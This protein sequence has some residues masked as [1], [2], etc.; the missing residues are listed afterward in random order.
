VSSAFVAHVTTV[1]VDS[2]MG[3]SLPLLEHDF[4]LSMEFIGITEKNEYLPHSNSF[5][6]FPGDFTQTYDPEVAL[7][8]LVNTF[9]SDIKP[10]LPPP[11]GIDRCIQ[12]LQ[13]AFAFHT[14]ISSV[15]NM[16]EYKQKAQ[17]VIKSVTKYFSV[18]SGNIDL[19]D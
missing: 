16:K 17:D 13:A 3:Q 9:G 2:N 5:D 18:P 4:S 10:S 1:G 15:T 14:D 6:E 12:N 11:S 19:D 7:L 8:D